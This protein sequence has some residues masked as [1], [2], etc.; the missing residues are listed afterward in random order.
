MIVCMVPHFQVLRQKGR[1]GTLLG[2]LLTKRNYRVPTASQLLGSASERTTTILTNIAIVHSW[3][4]I[5]MDSTSPGIEPR[6][7]G[8]ATTG[9]PKYCTGK[10]SLSLS[11][12]LQQEDWL[13]TLLGSLMVP[14]HRLLKKYFSTRIRIQRWSAGARCI[15][16]QAP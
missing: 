7:L 4:C 2:N 1:I 12:W 14:H 6:I 11:G 3:Y 16:G 8:T 13:A 9:K 15:L 10:H 5:K